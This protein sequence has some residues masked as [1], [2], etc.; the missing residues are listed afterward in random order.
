MSSSGTCLGFNTICASDGAGAASSECLYSQPTY[1]LLFIIDGT[2]SMEPWFAAIKTAIIQLSYIKEL[3]G[4]NITTQFIVFRDYTLREI[5]S[6]NRIRVVRKSSTKRLETSSEFNDVSQAIEFLE[7]MDIYGNTDI[8]EAVKTGLHTALPLITEN[9]ILYII[10]DALPHD[11]VDLS[12]LPLPQGN[13][14]RD[15][16]LQYYRDVAANPAKYNDTT[17]RWILSQT[18]L[19]GHE[20]ISCQPIMFHIAWIPISSSYICHT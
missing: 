20:L 2:A 16:A 17:L 5:G 18:Q 14:T 8:E 10:T 15:A 19:I 3:T 6:N 4:L 7:R 1:K 12:T 9:T 11:D 13:T